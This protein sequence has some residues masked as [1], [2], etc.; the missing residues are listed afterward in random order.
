[1]MLGCL[2]NIACLRAR[3]IMNDKF[4]EP[5]LFLA[6]SEKLAA[7]SVLDMSPIT[8]MLVAALKAGIADGTTWMTEDF[9]V[10]GAVTH[11]AFIAHELQRSNATVKSFDKTLHDITKLVR[12]ELY[13]PK[14]KVNVESATL[15]ARALEVCRWGYRG[16]IARAR[17]I[18]IP[19][20]KIISPLPSPPPC[21]HHGLRL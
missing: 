8:D 12:G 2:E 19:S 13:D 4:T 17:R 18:T 1:M 15:T 21:K 11:P 16:V 14:D 3:A 6:A 5:M 20:R 9:A 10:F 7:W